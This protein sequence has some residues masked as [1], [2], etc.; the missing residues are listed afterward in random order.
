MV[1]SRPNRCNLLRPKQK[2]S[3]MWNISTGFSTF[4]IS[5]SSVMIKSMSTFAWMKSPSV[6]RRTVPLIPIKQCS[7]RQCHVHTKIYHESCST[8]KC[9][10]FLIDD[11]STHR[12]YLTS[13]WLCPTFVLWNTAFGSSAL[14]LPGLFLLVLIQQISSHRL[15][16]HFLKH[17]D[18]CKYTKS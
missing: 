4:P 14:V 12:L 1:E 13:V 10:F 11:A 9:I 2:C 8:F 15:K 18:G 16:P 3:M 7:C 6:L 17:W 5:G